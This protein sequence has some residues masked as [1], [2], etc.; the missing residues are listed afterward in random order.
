MPKYQITKIESVL[1]IVF[2]TLAAWLMMMAAI[3]MYLVWLPSSP[4]GFLAMLALLP[5][6]FLLAKQGLRAT[7]LNNKMH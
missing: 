6:S 5:L 2:T 4:L 3:C 7:T 1:A